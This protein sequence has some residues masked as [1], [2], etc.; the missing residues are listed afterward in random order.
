[1]VPREFLKTVATRVGISDNELEVMARAI[2]GEPMTTISKHLGV[3][4]DALQKRLGEVYRKLNITGAGP[5]KLA[6]LQQRL[7]AEYQSEGNQLGGQNG[8]SGRKKR[9][10]GG[11]DG[12]GFSSNVQIDWGSA[13]RLGAFYGRSEALA[14]LKQ[15]LVTE[16]APL[17][18]VEGIG[19]IGKTALGVKLVQ[20]IAPDFDQ[21]I[22]RSLRDKPSPSEFIAATFPATSKPPSNWDDSEQIA[23][24]IKTLSNSRYLLIIDEVEYISQLGSKDAAFKSYEVLLQQLSESSHRSSVLLMG[25]E[26]PPSWQKFASKPS[27][28]LTGLSEQDSQQ[29]LLSGQESL[30]LDGKYLSELVHLCG[31]NPLILKLWSAKIPD[32]TI[33]NLTKLIKQNTLVIEELVRQH[34]RADQELSELEIRLVCWLAVNPKPATLSELATDLIL[35]E[36]GTEVQISLDFLIERSLLETVRSSQPI[37][38]TINSN[39]KKEIWYQLMGKSFNELGYKHYL[40]GEFQSAK[41]DLLQAVRYHPALSAGHYNLGSTYEKLEQFEPAKKHYQILVDVDNNRAAQAAVNNL[42]RL[43]IL[44]GKTHEAIDKLEKTLVQVKDKGVRSA[45][46]KNLGWAYFLQNNPK[47]AEV[48]LRQSLELKESNAVAYYILAQV[49][50]AQNRHKQA[51]AFWKTALEQDETDQQ[52]NGVTWRLPELLTWRMM[53]RQ[54]LQ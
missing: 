50:E 2:Q 37:G 35:S 23:E 3:R 6:K 39:F 45:L 13:P 16:R 43:E 31:G 17:V 1:M 18:M 53:A 26:I 5:G 25:W 10:L 21:V 52:S 11:V 33:G 32:L 4:K 49:L 30:Y 14:T 24:F 15:G 20:E 34:L 27:I 9:L 44:E 7:L 8:Q 41:T 47:Q 38:Y 48:E 46:H 12:Q 51:L 40:E 29:M 19:G 36:T 54:R 28:Q 22:W 42:A